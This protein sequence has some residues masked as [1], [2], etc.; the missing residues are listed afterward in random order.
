MS[1]VCRESTLARIVPERD[2]LTPAPHAQSRLN[3]IDLIPRQTSPFRAKKD[4]EDGE[5]LTADASKRD[6][7]E[8]RHVLSPSFYA[9]QELITAIRKSDGVCR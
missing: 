4:S 8:N 3:S 7:G 2:F 9:A 1:S 5:A 6:F